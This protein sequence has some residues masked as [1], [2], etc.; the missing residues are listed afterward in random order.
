MILLLIYLQTLS[1]WTVINPDKY[2]MSREN[3]V[4]TIFT[5]EK[6]TME[7]FGGISQR[8]DASPYQGKNIQFSLEMQTI[9]LTSEAGIYVII[10]DE[11][12][13]KISPAGKNHLSITDCNQ[14]WTTYSVVFF[15][16]NE[17]NSISFGALLFGSGEIA[18]RNYQLASTSEPITEL[19]PSIR[20]K[21]DF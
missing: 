3:E 21:E 7:H 20:S 4:I 14:D 5:M 8:I 19:N 13:E 9:D 10:R 16:P 1:E 6:L 12:N 18:I 11:N 17:A 2:Q 15:V